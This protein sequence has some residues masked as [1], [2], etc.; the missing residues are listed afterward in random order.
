M[1]S[2][3][4]WKKKEVEERQKNSRR[5]LGRGL[6]VGDLLLEDLEVRVEAGGL[7][8]VFVF[9]WSRKEE[10]EEGTSV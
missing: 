2:K 6:D 1:E 8:F 3:R 5:T 7:F 9:V 4:D 10:E